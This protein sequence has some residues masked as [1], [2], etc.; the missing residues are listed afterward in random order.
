MLI[1]PCI[2]VLLYSRCVHCSHRPLHRAEHFAEPGLNWHTLRFLHGGQC[3]HLSPLCLCGIHGQSAHRRLPPLLLLHLHPLHPLVALPA[4]WHGK[5][6]AARRVHTGRG[7]RL[8][9]V[10][11]LRAAVSEARVLGGAAYAVDSGDLDLPQCVLARIDGQGIVRE[12]WILHSAGG[13]GVL[14]VQCA[15]EF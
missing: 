12:V 15:C 13:F 3:R 6:P 11:V 5:G 9:R 14:T 7:Q 8:V 2:F 1:S 4:S 10:P